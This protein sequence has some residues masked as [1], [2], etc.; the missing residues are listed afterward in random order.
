M[1]SKLQNAIAA[2]NTDKQT[3]NNLERRVAEERR[4]RN[5]AES[6]LTQERK[7]RKQEEARAAAQVIKII[8]T[9]VIKR[10]CPEIKDFLWNLVIT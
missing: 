8:V 6:Q 4:A 2:R 3:I 1:Q 9:H 7:S 5:N 10:F